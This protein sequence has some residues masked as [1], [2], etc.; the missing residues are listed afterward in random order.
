MSKN[1]RQPL[2]AKKQLLVNKIERQ[3]RDLA[4]TSEDWLQ[5]TAPYDR[6][7]KTFITFRPLFIAATGLL[8]IYSLK[9]PKRILQLGKK[10]FTMWGIART[11][12]STINTRKK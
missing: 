12:Q 9:K 6:A 5:V 8:S 7:W 10:A 2:A 1:K 11:I 4:N 3:R